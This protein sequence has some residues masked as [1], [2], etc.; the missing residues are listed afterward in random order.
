MRKVVY[1]KTQIDSI[2]KTN[3]QKILNNLVANDSKIEN[4]CNVYH[5]MLDAM[6]YLH[7]IIW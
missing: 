3:K 5:S 1:K 4:A 6:K 7:N 2:K